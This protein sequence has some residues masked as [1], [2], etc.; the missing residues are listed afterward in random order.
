[1]ENLVADTGPFLYPCIIEYSLICSA[2]TYVMWKH[3]G[4]NPSKRKVIKHDEKTK[5]ESYQF[6]CSGANRGLFAGILVFILTCISLMVFFM[7][8]NNEQFSDS[9]MEV[10]A[11]HSSEITLYVLSSIAV[12]VAFY[13]MKFLGYDCQHK[14]ELDH[15]LLLVAQTGLFMYSVFVVVGGHSLYEVENLLTF[16]AGIT[17]FLQAILQTM[18]LLN[19]TRCY[20]KTKEH[21]TQKPG[22][23]MV[24]FLI[25]SNLSMWAVNTFETLNASL[26]PGQFEFYGMWAWTIILHLSM[27]LAIFYRFHSTVV[28]CEIWSTAYERKHTA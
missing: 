20:A 9:N 22:R 17:E 6:D 4:K 28:L 24:T 18:F 27:P 26:H 14:V 7:L 23:E 3:T 10:I 25:M 11:A 16:L 13:Q 5:V 21:E 19:A 8:K 2:I 12:V 1:M 15:I